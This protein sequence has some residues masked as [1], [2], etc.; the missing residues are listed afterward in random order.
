MKID[1]ESSNFENLMQYIITESVKLKNKC[2]KEVDVK[3]EFG[4]IFCQSDEEYKELVGEIKNLGENVYSTK[5]GDIYRLDKPLKTIA[6]DLYFVK[7]RVA[8]GTL[9]QRGDADFDTDY[10]P[11]KEKYLHNPHF[12]LVI[13]EEFEMLRLSDPDFDVMTCF[14]NIPVRTWTKK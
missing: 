13:K 8:D 3:V 7:A 2:A 1:Q 12:E 4:D 6:G 10:L 9:K 11:F 14:S 5:T